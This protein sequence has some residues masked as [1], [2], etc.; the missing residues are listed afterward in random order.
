LTEGT[1][2][3]TCVI[4]PNKEPRGSRHVGGSDVAVSSAKGRAAARRRRG[5]RGR[6]RTARSA[7]PARRG[8][9]PALPRSR[10]QPTR[11]ER[12][13]EPDAGP[14]LEGA[15]GSGAAPGAAETDTSEFEAELGLLAA[16]RLASARSRA[17]S[18]LPRER[19]EARA[20]LEPAAAARASA[21]TSSPSSV[22]SDV[23]I[24]TARLG[25]PTAVAAGA[26]RAGRGGE[27]GLLAPGSEASAERETASAAR[28]S[29]RTSS[30]SSVGSDVGIA[31]ARLGSPTAVAADDL[32]AA[33]VAERK[34]KTDAV[35][36][37]KAAEQV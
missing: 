34:E 37:F 3:G 20:A 12:M 17:L 33:T 32:T 24:A 9:G 29:A 15:P 14:T 5:G 8:P 23:G 35:A 27:L 21:R 28:A 10:M 36:A 4:G 22:G 25:S 6:R 31:T 11:D 16:R 7:G 1:M 30:P 26:A 13:A 2:N 19:A 18:L